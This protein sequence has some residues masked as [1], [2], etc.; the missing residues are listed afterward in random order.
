MNLDK[1]GA[2]TPSEYTKYRYIDR[3]L[4][5]LGGRVRSA[6]D[7]GCGV[8][9]LLLALEDNRIESKGIDISDESLVMGRAR[10]KSPHIKI[11]KMSV[12]DLKER[13]DLVYL[14]DVLEH[15]PDDAG[16]L[17]RLHDNIVNKN[18]YLIITVPAHR[19]LYSRFD[20]NAGHLRRYDKA[21][22]I[23]LLVES[24]FE[25]I[26]CWSYG[27]VIA[28]IAANLSL[29][30]E[31]DWTK[32]KKSDMGYNERTLASAIRHFGGIIRPFVSKVN[33]LHRVLY[34]LDY[35]LRKLDLG[36]EYCLLCKLR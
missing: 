2:I 31:Q 10:V 23:S 16:L 21:Q 35:S 18:G 7:V 5:G 36:I 28:H 26:L 12:F 1:I 22:L 3:I 25:P 9:N 6:C 15:I 14:T 4:A 32:M 19:L 20:S 24:G 30:S 8:G 13:F 33:I 34:L 17:R 27:S 11:E 29:L